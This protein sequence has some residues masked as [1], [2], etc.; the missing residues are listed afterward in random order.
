MT[1]KEKLEE[2]KTKYGSIIFQSDIQNTFL[3][4]YFDLDWV[5]MM[6][7]KNSITEQFDLVCKL[8]NKEEK[9]FWSSVISE[10]K[11][12]ESIELKKRDKRP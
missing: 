1:P 10:Y 5:L 8:S 3:N 4:G 12:Y 2:I 9:S 7:V 11:R 6:C